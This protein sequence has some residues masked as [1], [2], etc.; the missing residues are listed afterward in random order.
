MHRREHICLSVYLCGNCK[1]HS[2]AY[3]GFEAHSD[4]DDVDM[5]V[6]ATVFTDYVTEQW[7]EGDKRQ[8]NNFETVVPHI[9]N[10]L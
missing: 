1:C 5:P 2:W 6:A 9:T 3:R 7:V 8:W 10:N 4:I